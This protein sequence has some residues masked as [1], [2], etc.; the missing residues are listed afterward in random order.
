MRLYSIMI[1]LITFHHD[2]KYCGRSQAIGGVIIDHHIPQN[3]LMQI[4]E[5][6]DSDVTCCSNFQYTN[7]TPD[8]DPPPSPPPPLLAWNNPMVAIKEADEGEGEGRSAWA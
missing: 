7:I 5:I 4:V 3:S 8:R 6:I 1:E 2:R